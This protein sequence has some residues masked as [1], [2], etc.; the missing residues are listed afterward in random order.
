M[1]CTEEPDTW[2][3]SGA[4]TT[5]EILVSGDCHHRQWGI[6]DWSTSI[7]FQSSLRGP[8]VIRG[9]CPLLHLRQNA[10]VKD[11]TFDCLSSDAAIDIVDGRGVVLDN[12]SALHA[13]VFKAAHVEGVS[14]AGKSERIQQPSRDRSHRQR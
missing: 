2:R 13:S 14:L 8:A 1:S 3:Q 12:V 5:T 9:H 10:S 11:I 4:Q 7:A 6:V